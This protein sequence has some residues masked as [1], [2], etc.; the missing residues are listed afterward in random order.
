MRNEPVGVG[1]SRQFIFSS[2]FP[3]EYPLNTGK[4]F[5]EIP[6]KFP[7]NVS[8]GAISPSC[9]IRFGIGAYCPDVEDGSEAGSVEGSGS[10]GVTVT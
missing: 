1:P 10:V 2:L 3:T 9:V 6:V 4:S 8:P 7:D 5:Y